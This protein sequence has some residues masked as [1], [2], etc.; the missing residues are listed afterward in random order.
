MKLVTGIL[1]NDPGWGILFDQIGVEWKA[2]TA[3]DDITPDEFSVVVVNTNPTSL[4]EKSLLE[5]VHDGGALVAT[6]G[7]ADAMIS[8]KAKKKYFGSLPP[9]SFNAVSVNGMMDLYANGYAELESSPTTGA[10]P[11]IHKM[12]KGML[13]TIPFDVGGLIIDTRAMRKNFYFDMPRLPNEVTSAVSK[14]LLRR[15]IADILQYVHLQRAIPFIHKWYFPEARQSLFTFRVD[16]DH[17][18]REEVAD[19]ENLCRTH[20]IKTMWFIDTKSHEHWLSQFGNFGDQEIGLHCY[21][22]FTYASDENNALNFRKALSLL[23][24]EGVHPKGAAAPYGTWNN[25]VASIFG[26]L[27]IRYS[28]EFSLD[29]DDLPFFPSL[30]T[31]SSPVLQIPIHPIC[32]GSMKRIGYTVP[33]M[34]RYFRQA[35]DTKL[36][37]REPLAFYHHPTHHHLDIFEEMFEYVRSRHIENFSYAEY[38]DW[39]KTRGTVD[40]KF[41]YHRD[42]NS[43]VADATNPDPAVYWRIVYPNGEESITNSRGLIPVQSLPR[44][45]QEDPSPVPSDI[46]R[47]R[48]FDPRHMLL[49]VLDA[50]Y[51]RTQ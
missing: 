7:A 40:W 43:I 15:L 23:E 34:K 41:E 1:C 3:S 25:S 14:G 9:S 10:I 5:Y 2:I 37:L 21:E 17:G 12:G 30:G 45:R 48:R 46:E 4:Q 6:D 42:E 11:S 18:S 32:V 16:S 49:N 19:L 27:G 33:E 50:W 47:S 38:A 20:R 22:H 26:Q 36:L 51:K 44:Q 35:I 8:S 24:A 28:S 39:W 29:Y 13:I 31:K